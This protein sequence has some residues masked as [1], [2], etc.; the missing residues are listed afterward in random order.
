MPNTNF[1]PILAA[2]RIQSSGL[3]KSPAALSSLLPTANDPCLVV[4]AAGFIVAANERAAELLGRQADSLVGNFFGTWGPELDHTDLDLIRV[5]NGIAET[6][7]VRA[8]RFTDDS[9]YTPSGQISIVFEPLV[10]SMPL[11]TAI[12]STALEVQDENLSLSFFQLPADIRV[13][14]E[15]QAMIRA[16]VVFFRNAADSGQADLHI[17][18]CRDASD[19]QWLQVEFYLHQPDPP[20]LRPGTYESHD[21]E[22][23]SD[24]VEKLGGT[25]QLGVEYPE[26]NAHLRI[27]L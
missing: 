24:A 5:R 4:D 2:L 18:A 19:P 9:V 17:R 14:R 13:S 8:R 15:F 21:L 12:G 3:W 10:E 26:I 1:N 20:P 11:S 25:F 6:S 16:W 22:E 7:S 23:A 27:P